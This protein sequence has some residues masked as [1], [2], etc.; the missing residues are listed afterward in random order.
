MPRKARKSRVKPVEFSWW[1]NVY[2]IARRC[3]ECGY[4]PENTHW[5]LAVSE[6]EAMLGLE[7]WEPDEP[8]DLPLSKKQARERAKKH[9]AMERRFYD[10][11]VR[12]LY[13]AG[14]ITQPPESQCTWVTTTPFP[15]GWRPSQ[16]SLM[17]VN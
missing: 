2:V 6:R 3:Q 9:N 17:L 12:M 4:S 10:V 13:R 11:W 5:R 7:E 1:A 8:A 14:E 15:S 16:P